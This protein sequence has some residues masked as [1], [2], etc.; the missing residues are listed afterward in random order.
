MKKY[1]YLLLI[2][3]TFSH[4]TINNDVYANETIDHDY[5][6]IYN[7]IPEH[8]KWISVTK[9]IGYGEYVPNYSSTY[10]YDDGIYSGVLKE[11]TAERRRNG[12]RGDK[13]YA[14]Y[15]TYNGYVV[16]YSGYRTNNVLP[17]EE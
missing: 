3:I 5:M 11:Y 12:G 17:I 9:F 14:W 16:S 8:T 15:M 13:M 2:F 1:I 7:K 10:F 6:K 4:I